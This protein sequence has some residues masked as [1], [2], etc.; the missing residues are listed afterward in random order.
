[1]L[2]FNFCSFYQSIVKYL[3]N[4]QVYGMHLLKFLKM[5]RFIFYLN[6]TNRS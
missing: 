1:M 3:W 5:V 6:P 4:L 2:H